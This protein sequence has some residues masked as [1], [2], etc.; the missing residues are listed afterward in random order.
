MTYMSE[1][2][3]L[4]FTVELCR[5]LEVLEVIKGIQKNIPV[6]IKLHFELVFD[7]VSALFGFNTTYRVVTIL[8][9]LHRVVYKI[10]AIKRNILR[11]LS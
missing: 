4:E 5:G 9:K 2:M 10:L 1:D 3:Q 8:T 6:K 7:C 11:S